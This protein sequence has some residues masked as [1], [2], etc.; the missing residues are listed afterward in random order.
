MPRFYFDITDNKIE[1]D[2]HGV[3]LEGAERGAH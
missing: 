1:V 2:E 3:K